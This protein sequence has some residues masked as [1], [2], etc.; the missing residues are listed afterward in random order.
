MAFLKNGDYKNVI[1][2]KKEGNPKALAIVQAYLK[3]ASQEDLDRMLLDFYGNSPVEPEEPATV[4]EPKVGETPIEDKIE[5]EPPAVIEDISCVLDSDLDGILDVDEISD[6]SFDDFIAEKKRNAKRLS[7]SA[8]YFKRYD[9]AGREAYIKKK[10]DEYGKSFDGKKRDI[11]RFYRDMDSS[12]GSHLQRIGDLPDD[13]IDVSPES[14]DKAYADM[15]ESFGNGHS[16][17]RS[18]DKEDAEDMIAVLSELVGKYGKRNVIAA[19][20]IVRGDNEA[21]RDMRHGKI[22]SAISKYNKQLEGLLK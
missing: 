15:V 21:F 3:G 22:D 4:E 16:I 2:A 14:S 10:E 6:S 8:E 5:E 1:R 17:G 11:D 7:N 18:W 9:P 13:E 19:L 20:N 12:I